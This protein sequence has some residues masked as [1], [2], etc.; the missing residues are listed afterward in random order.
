MMG[1]N[2]LAPNAIG[3]VPVSFRTKCSHFKQLSVRKSR[4]FCIPRLNAAAVDC[5]IR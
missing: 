4:G 1:N 2:D 3:L 5:R